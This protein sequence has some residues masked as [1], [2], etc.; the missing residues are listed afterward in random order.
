MKF[1]CGILLHSWKNPG[2]QIPMAP[3]KFFVTTSI[4]DSNFSCFTYG[5]AVLEFPTEYHRITHLF[6]PAAKTVFNN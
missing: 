3:R 6:F 5:F 4:C 2:S 1:V